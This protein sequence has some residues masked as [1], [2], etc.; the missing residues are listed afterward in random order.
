MKPSSP[1]LP[2]LRPLRPPTDPVVAG[3]ARAGAD[4]D[5]AAGA[6]VDAVDVALAAAVVALPPQLEVDVRHG[7]A[8][9]P[10]VPVG[11]RLTSRQAHVVLSQDSD[12]YSRQ[13]VAF[14]LPSFDCQR[15]S[16][17]IVSMLSLN[18]SPSF[19]VSTTFR[20][21]LTS[22]SGVQSRATLYPGILKSVV[23]YRGTHKKS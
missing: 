20:G 13:Q 1:Q 6:D 18:V 9:N 11:E 17:K 23:V 5:G 16:P 3:A 8:G 10:R 19:G 22:D 15:D 7:P 21:I 14:A 2:L 12:P 4:V